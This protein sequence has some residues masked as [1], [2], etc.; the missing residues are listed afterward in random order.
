MAIR[1][2]LL[3]LHAQN[4]R[5]GINHIQNINP[6]PLHTQEIIIRRVYMQKVVV[7]HLYHKISS[8]NNKSTMLQT[9]ISLQ[10]A[11][12]EGS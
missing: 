7:S 10:E 11:P 4:Q 2:Y 9:F 3:D 5:K 6:C 8:E 12:A 1:K